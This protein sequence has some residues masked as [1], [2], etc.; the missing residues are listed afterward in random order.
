MGSNNTKC[1][2]HKS[3]IQWW[4]LTWL[5]HDLTTHNFIVIITYV[6]GIVGEQIAEQLNCGFSDS[7][8]FEVSSSNR[9]KRYKLFP[10]GKL[11]TRYPITW[12]IIK[13]TDDMP[14]SDVDWETERSFQ[15]RSYNFFVVEF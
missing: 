14:M 15:V 3:S 2:L 9:E 13:Y 12:D 1:Q 10:H 8:Q 7:D 6:L 4:H 5:V 11:D